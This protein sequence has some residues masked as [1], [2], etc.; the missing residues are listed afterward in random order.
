[1]LSA[2]TKRCYNCGKVKD[3]TE[4]M[5]RKIAAD[6]YRSGCRDC[7][8]EFTKTWRKLNPVKNREIY[9]KSHKKRHSSAS[10]RLN[11]S[12]RAAICETI[13]RGKGGRKTFDLLGYTLN[14][15]MAHL[16]RQFLKGMRWGNYGEWHIDHI[17]PLSSFKI[18]GADDPELMRAWGLTNL[19]P[20]WAKD[21]ISK[22]CKITH[23]I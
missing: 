4:F 3:K 2:P 21:N 7:H 12:M 15:L 6:G 23:L 5:P 22:G 9:T 20:I 17:K 19:R 16:E 10:Y 18:A 13:R 11:A 14:E 8:R 1:M